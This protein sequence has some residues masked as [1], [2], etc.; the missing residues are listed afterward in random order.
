[1][2]DDAIIAII[3]V[4]TIMRALYQEPR[5]DFLFGGFIVPEGIDSKVISN[6]SARAQR[7]HAWEH[8][9]QNV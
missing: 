7:K 1:M 3:I 6:T 2:H 5:N 8:T 4:C 9:Q